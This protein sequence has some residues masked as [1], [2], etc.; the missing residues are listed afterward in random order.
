LS[1]G[2]VNLSAIASLAALTV[3]ASVA[4]ADNWQL[5]YHPAQAEYAIYGGGLGDPVAPAKGDR[6][7]AFAIHG[8]AAKDIFDSMG[9][10]KPD[11]CSSES[12]T[13]L[14]SQDHDR[15][16]C[17]LDGGNG[18]YSCYFGFDLKSGKS[19]GGSVC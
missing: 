3:V 15:L 18:Q 2:S 5:A 13:Q 10:D 9:P 17:T 1:G 7:V 16:T 4:V 14:R 11:R 6:K 12:G 19:V 8:N